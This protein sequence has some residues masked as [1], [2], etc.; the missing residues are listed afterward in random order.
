VIA[1][2]EAA[3]VACEVVTGGGSGS[4]EFDL[5][6]GVYTEIQP[7]SYVFMDADYGAN[8]RGRCA[9][10]TACSSPRRS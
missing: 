7:G 9:S 4:V 3:G 2:L 6:S 8:T 1:Q 10:S 5:A